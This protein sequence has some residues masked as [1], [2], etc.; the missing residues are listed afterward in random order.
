MNSLENGFLLGQVSRRYENGEIDDLASISNY[1]DRLGDL[2]GPL[3]HQAA[4][5]YLNTANYVKVILMPESS[6]GK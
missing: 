6:G 2:T 4:M 3:I 5:N 1:A